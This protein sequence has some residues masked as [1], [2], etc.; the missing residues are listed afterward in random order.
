[1]SKYEI[2]NQPTVDKINEYDEDNRTYYRFQMKDWEMGTQSWGMIYNTPEE[3]IEDGSTVL[4]GKSCCS[5]ANQLWDFAQCFDKDFRV[6]VVKGSYV[7]EG[8]DGEEVVEIDE[9]VEIWGFNEFIA[10][11]QSV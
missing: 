9:I 8:H 3:A 6:L 4:E 5:T 2:N 11:M 10:C 7:E 1:M